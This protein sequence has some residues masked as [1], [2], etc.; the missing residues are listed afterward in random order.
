MFF[1]VLR[2]SLL[3]ACQGSAKAVTAANSWSHST[4]VLSLRITGKKNVL[5]ENDSG[6]SSRLR[7]YS[8]GGT[9]SCSIPRDHF[10]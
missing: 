5:C 4:R 3:L 1:A 7:C 9:G 8:A 10:S 2:N 6:T